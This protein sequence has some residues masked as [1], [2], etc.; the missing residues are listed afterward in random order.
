[1]GAT[2]Y[3]LSVKGP[4][5]IFDKLNEIK[6]DMLRE[7][8]ANARIAADEFAKNAG[9]KVASIQTARQGGFSIRDANNHETQTNEQRKLVRVVSSITFYLQD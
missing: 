1:M 3:N 8:T 9:V 5:Y 7:A 4:Q 6:P 2:E